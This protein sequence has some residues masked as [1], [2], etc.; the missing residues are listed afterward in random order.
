MS[1]GILLGSLL[2]TASLALSE[3][4]SA[5]CKT[6]YECTGTGGQVMVP[7]PDGPVK[8]PGN[9]ATVTQGGEGGWTASLSW[10][11]ESSGSSWNS[12][13]GSASGT[14]GGGSGHSG[15]NRPSRG[16]GNGDGTDPNFGVHPPNG[17]N[18]QT[19]GSS[20]GNAV[21]LAVHGAG[22]SLGWMSQ[23]QHWGFV[24]SNSGHQEGA[25]T[26]VQSGTNSWQCT[27]PPHGGNGRPDP[28]Q[29]DS[30]NGQQS[31]DSTQQQP[32]QRPPPPSQ[33]QPSEPGPEPVQEPPASKP[34]SKFP[35]STDDSKPCLGDTIRTWNRFYHY[36]N[37]QYPRPNAP[38][39]FELD[40]VQFSEPTILE[41]VDDYYQ[42]GHYEVFI[43]DKSVGETQENGFKN[44]KI[45]C[46]VAD[47]C[48]QKGFSHGF[49]LIP[50]APKPSINVKHI[51]QNPE[52]YSQNCIDRNYKDLQGHPY[53]IKE[54]FDE[55][56]DLQ[57]N[58]RG[59][60]ERRNFLRRKL[61]NPSSVKND[62][63]SYDLS[64]ES[65]EE[66]LEEARSLKSQLADIETQ[67]NRRIAKMN[68]LAIQLPNTT[69]VESP[70]GTTP[71]LVGYINEHTEPSPRHSDRVWTN[72][73]HIGSELGLID[74]TAAGTTSGWGWYYLTNEAALLEQALIQYALSVAMKKGWKVVSPPSIVYSHIAAAC[75][76]RPRDQ[77]GEQQVY[78]L[79]QG[80]KDK[81]R[82]KPELSLAATA[83]IPLAAMKANQTL[84]EDDMPMKV[85]GASRCYRAEA[86]A[87]GVDTKGL[88]RVHE[89]T[90]VEMFAWTQ[91]DEPIG[92][93]ETDFSHSALVFDEMVS[94][95]TEILQSLGLHCRILEMPSIDLGASATRK[96][97]IE[98]Y[99]PSRR[100]RDEG[101][102]E[103]T[104]A[105]IC[106][107]YQTRR[108]GTNLR[109]SKLSRNQD[110]PHTVN[111]TAMAVPRIIAALLENGW[112]EREHMVVLPKILKPWMGG[113][114]VIQ[115]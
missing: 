13:D 101:W 16:D 59:L 69:S 98:A 56:Q 44:E 38:S 80:E 30:T 6:T 71:K 100:D 1:R 105:S 86:G 45:G 33:Q 21:N 88:Y 68:E 20:G 25:G 7:G 87:R 64:T 27:C 115:K 77:S 89:F 84:E 18:S 99:F 35:G 65:R 32:I 70:I 104:S 107:D 75:G 52:S 82:G 91:P 4:G 55:W 97:D 23:S 26:L 10:G 36:W 109:L 85:V 39:P 9:S 72:H 42:T 62:E 112:D 34:S 83:E 108:L 74:F 31:Q 43:D 103:V 78:A 17:G 28:G 114:N 58:G 67:E 22:G 3:F 5:Q 46:S 60:R 49:F 12:A 54:L 63:T 51:R 40:I 15:G 94:I 110:F 47:D 37:A 14:V 90:K 111:G 8:L 113:I 93:D 92:I 102:G 81:A 95:Q 57:V 50:E 24:Q 76:F 79:Q 2:F 61:T 19:T 29:T 41:I 53:R 66:V 73:V 48:I 106:T 96:R 11:K